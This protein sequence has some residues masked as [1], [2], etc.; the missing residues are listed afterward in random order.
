MN[1]VDE[2]EVGGPKIKAEDIKPSDKPDPKIT[3]DEKP[4]PLNNK[5]NIS[6]FEKRREVS[7]KNCRVFD[8]R[9]RHLGDG[10]YCLVDEAGKE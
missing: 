2:G 8:E 7:N 4:E 5:E 1:L 9:D 3:S 10:R 6:D